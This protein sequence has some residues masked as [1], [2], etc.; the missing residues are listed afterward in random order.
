[1]TDHLIV[2][3]KRATLRRTGW[4]FVIAL[5]IILAACGNGGTTGY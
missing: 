2:N 1:M 4:L 5:P 3:R